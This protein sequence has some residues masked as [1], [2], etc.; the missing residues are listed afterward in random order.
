MRSRLK[1]KNKIMLNFV[2]QT[3]RVFCFTG[4]PGLVVN[5]RKKVRV[6]DFIKGFEH[7]QI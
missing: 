2:V 1:L 3:Y 5:Q 4:P 6:W 7:S